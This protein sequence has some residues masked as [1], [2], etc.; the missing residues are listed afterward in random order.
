MDERE[1]QRRQEQ[2]RLVDEWL[3]RLHREYPWRFRGLIVAVVVA[4][5]GAAMLLRHFLEWL[6]R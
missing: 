5:L 2:L 6:G 4:I 3:Q 1:R